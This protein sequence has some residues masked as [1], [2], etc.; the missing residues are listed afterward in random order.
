M[1]TH[2][3]PERDCQ[4]WNLES[5]VRGTWKLDVEVESRAARRD[6]CGAVPKEAEPLV[7]FWSFSVELGEGQDK[8]EKGK[9]LGAMR[10][11]CVIQ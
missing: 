5:V 7:T 6:T 11:T 4:P 1:R 10:V 3:Q 8:E 2:S 9:K